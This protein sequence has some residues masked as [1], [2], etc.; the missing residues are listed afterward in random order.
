MRNRGFTIVELLV[1]IGVLAL[2]IGILAP[3]L[4]GVGAG[5]RSMRCQSNL[6]QMAIAAQNYAAVYDAYPA[7][8][9]FENVN[10]TF[11]RIAW[12][13]VTTFS[14]QLISP[15]PLWAFSNNPDDV[16]QCPD[17]NSSATF[18]GDPYT[19]YNY[20]TSFIGG[21]APFPLTGWDHVR[22]GV[23]PF[24]CRRASQ[25]AIFGD[26]GWKGGANKFMRAPGNSEGI[27]LAILYGGGQAFRHG[28]A[29]NVAFIDGHVSS[30]NQAHQGALATP[31]NLAQIMDFPTNGFLSEDDRAY[32]PR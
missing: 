23:P 9:R 24:A 22:R 10:G 31:G 25:C 30:V 3:A 16:Q 27:S 5:G 28:H 4:A 29:T 6:R 12:D 18:G 21:E 1:V 20:N 2:L 13:W 14:N 15:G 7:A 17:C 26:G 11:E 8:I 32:D 19:G